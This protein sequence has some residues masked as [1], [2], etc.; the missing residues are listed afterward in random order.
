[1]TSGLRAVAAEADA[2][3]AAVRA[4]PAVAGLYGGGLAPVVTL[5]PGRRVDGVHV[6][7]DS[8]QLAVVA[9]YGPPLIALVDQVRAAVAP[10]AGGR[11]IDVCVADL[12]LPGEE[13]PALPATPEVSRV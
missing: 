9:A 7:D 11:R 5:L 6:D 13:Q 4:C 2:I 12:Q 8:V 10:L 3:A 1:M